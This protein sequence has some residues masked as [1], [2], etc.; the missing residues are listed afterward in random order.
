VETNDKVIL[1]TGAGRGIGADVVATLARSARVYGIDL[2]PGV[3]AAVV[4]AGGVKGFAADVADPQ[5]MQDAV[6]AVLAEAPRIDALV[7]AAGIHRPAPFLEASLDDLELLMRVNLYGTF[8]GSQIVARSMVERG[9][10]GAIINFTSVGAEHTTPNSAA[11]G[12][13]KGAVTSLT[14]GM[15]VS[16]AEYGITVNAIAPGPVETPMNAANR[17]N[18]EYVARMIERVPLGRQGQPADISALVEFLVGDGA[19][20]ITGEV[21]HVDGGISVLR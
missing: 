3:D 2:A 21:I 6:D 19:R 11:Y 16:L 15:A 1:V 9:V 8:I 20:W 17:E 14:R 7:N 4:A 10:A 13:S 12:A 18:P 5:A